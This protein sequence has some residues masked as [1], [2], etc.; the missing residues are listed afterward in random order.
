MLNVGTVSRPQHHGIVR[1]IASRALSRDEAL[2]QR[3][4]RAV[5]DF[6]QRACERGSLGLRG[7]MND[8]D[9]LA[10]RRILRDVDDDAISRHRGVERD[11]RIGRRSVQQQIGTR[12]ICRV[13]QHLAK[14][15]DLNS[16]L[17]RSVRKLGREHAVHQHQIMRAF[18]TQRRHGRLGAR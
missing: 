17:D 18:D 6:H 12:R 9:R 13:I 1:L 10:R 5:R 16:L 2:D 8:V 3:D 14:R 4:T 15:L 11:H 7:D